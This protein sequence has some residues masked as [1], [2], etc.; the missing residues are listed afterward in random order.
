[1]KANRNYKFQ[2][3]VFK[4]IAVILAVLLLVIVPIMMHPQFGKRP[5]GERLKRI[6]ESPQF[7][8]G[9]FQNTN[10]TPQITQNLYV[11]LY[12]YIF[13]GSKESRPKDII[14]SKSISWK[15]L[16]NNQHSLIWLGHSSYFL[17]IDGKNILVDPVL[18]GR[19]SP[20]VGSGKAFKGSEV[21]T[22]EDLPDI[23][24]LFIS[25]DHYDHMDYQTLV[26]LKD[27]VSKVIVGLGVGSHL[28]YWG[29]DSQQII[30]KDWWE[31]ID[32]GQGFNVRIT[33]ARHFSGRSIWSGNTL[34]VSFV[35]QTPSK[36]IYLGGDSGYDSHFKQIG[37]LFGPFDLAILENGQYDLSWKY[38]HMMPEQVIQAAQDLG[39]KVVFPVHSSKFVLANHPWYEPLQRV[40]KQALEQ[41]Q[42]IITPLIGQVVDLDN[43]Y[44]KPT[45]WW[46][47]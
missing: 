4:L 31:T 18:S 23:D 11:A 41:G 16:L 15:D 32:L 1:M 47:K 42:G 12:D 34:W 7:K 36:T 33:P 5:S 8:N 17:K 38:I 28:E 25:H 39:S 29:Y 46:Q 9:K 37:D 20:V 44:E 3:K 14:P 40:S 45:Y 27:K 21:A 30:E 2:K 19:A 10:H 13:G 26:K 22:V 24:Y 43:L 35:L 6:K